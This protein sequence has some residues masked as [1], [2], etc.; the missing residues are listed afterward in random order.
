MSTMKK[1]ITLLVLV[2]ITLQTNAQIEKGTW[3]LGGSASFSSNA[4]T[5]AGNSNFTTVISP[6]AGYFIKDK[7][8][9]GTQVA[10]QSQSSVYSSFS[11]APFVRYYFL[12]KDK[13]LN[14]FGNGSFGYQSTSYTIGGSASTTSWQLAA[15]PELFITDNIGLTFTL[16]YG[17]SSSGNS[18]MNTVSTN[19]V[20]QIHLNK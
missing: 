19:I 17:S 10:F 13:K 9:I 2:F 11:I 7:L 12:P 14:L 3:L 1:L 15:G 6:M 5:G 4:T 16:S 18:S 20:F 8:A